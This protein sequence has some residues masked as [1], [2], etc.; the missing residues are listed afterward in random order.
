MKIGVWLYEGLNPHV[1]GGSSYINRLV[2]LV[3]QYTFSKEVEVCFVQVSP[4]IS[5]SSFNKEVL[6]INQIPIFI[7]KIFCFSTLLKR[8]IIHIDREIIKARGLK[9]VLKGSEVRVIYYLKQTYVIDPYFPFISTNWDIGHRSTFPFPEVCGNKAFK[10][11]EHFYDNILPLALMV[12]CESETGKKELMNYTKI[13]NHKIRVMPMFSGGVCLL[14]VDEKLMCSYLDNIGLVKYKFFYYPAQFWAHKN[15][16]GLITAFDKFIKDERNRDYK[17]VLSG[18]DQGNL[19][20]IKNK[21]EEL[22]ISDRVLFLGFVSNEL[23]YT[24]YKNAT[25]LVMATHFGPTN[26]PPIEAMELG[27]PVTCSDIGGHREILDDAASYFDSFD[28]TSIYNSLN[29]MVNNHKYYT[30]KIVEQREKTIYNSDFAIS[31]LNSIFLEVVKIR[32]NWGA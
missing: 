11:R 28:Y 3:D 1:G 20:Y 5:S 18:S 9:K 17:L 31:R 12:I 10:F 29:D 4:I 22:G 6:C 25:C 30:D 32:E 16:I 24:L 21:V 7:Y 8:L 19:N 13:G 23:V 15:H 14:S 2:A 27:C 26:I